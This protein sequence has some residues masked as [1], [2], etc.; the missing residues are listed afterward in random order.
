MLTR[1]KKLAWVGALVLVIVGIAA[2]LTISSR[3][4]IMNTGEAVTAAPIKGTESLVGMSDGLAN[5]AEAV[6]PS[7]VNIST[8]KTVKGQNQ[9]SP[10]F[11]DPFFRRF[12]GDQ[13]GQGGGGGTRKFKQ[14]SLGSG[15]IVSQDGYIVTNNHVVDGA[16]DIKVVLADKSEYKAKVVGADSRSDVALIKIK[17]EGLPAMA[18]GD[19][20]KLRPGEMVM[21]IGS[22]FGLA[23]TVTVG[24]VSAV[25]RANVGIADYE[26]FIQTD[27]AINPGNS[28]GALVNMR[29]ELVGINT[30]I[31]S[32]SGGYQGIGFAVPAKM[33]RQVMESIR[34]TGKVV[35]G[36]LG[37]SVQNLSP[38][39]AK[40]FAA[41]GSKGALVSDVVKDSPA[42]KA[43]L[44]VGDVIVKLDGETVE[45]S[46]HL[47]NSVAAKPLGGKVELEV[48]RDKKKLEVA[49]TVGELPKE[50]AG[51]VTGEAGET[52]SALAGI[53]VQELT[54]DLTDK[55][56]LDK[57]VTGV[58]VVSVDQGSLAED[59]GLAR[60]DVIMSINR[61]TVKNV[62]DYN[63]AASKL[64]KDEP[65][66]L[67]LN[68][69]GSV[70]WMSIG[71]TD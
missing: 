42:E 55:L 51:A 56:G 47:R 29:G 31:F 40:E 7:V 52:V 27:A 18:W 26:D 53:S 59:A 60:G 61:A 64:K 17:A 13:F 65:V 24:I 23:R 43:G 11:D 69:Q 54:P 50:M 35:R 19:S 25:G 3:L 37:V 1:S 66:L 39:L 57:G 22:P 16:D 71:P 34:K 30:A 5:I 49:V 4:D 9:M 44:K 15:V 8:E 20:D 36:W 32:Q 28:G 45:D 21:A 2:G 12:F 67:L 33:A 48:I 46:G 10:F 6:T 41:E 58:V 70:L 62:K 68:R 14:S 38:Q 63:K